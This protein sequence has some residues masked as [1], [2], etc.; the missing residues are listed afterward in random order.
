MTIFVFCSQ[1]FHC[2]PISRG[3]NEVFTSHCCNK[4]ASM[5]F[6]PKELRNWPKTM[7]VGAI[8]VSATTEEFES[9]RLGLV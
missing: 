7:N 5:T 6:L 8:A 9:R 1:T 4:E 3:L 2:Q